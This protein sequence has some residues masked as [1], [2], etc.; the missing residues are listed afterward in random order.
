MSGA[1]M[2]VLAVISVATCKGWFAFIFWWIDQVEHV[3]YWSLFCFI[4]FC[5]FSLFCFICCFLWPPFPDVFVNVGSPTTGASVFEPAIIDANIDDTVVF[6]FLLVGQSATSGTSCKN[7]TY[8][9]PFFDSGI[10]QTT[11]YTYR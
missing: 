4:F 8:P 10:I 5:L 7:S 2:L 1:L 9:V 6:V 11:G 3:Y